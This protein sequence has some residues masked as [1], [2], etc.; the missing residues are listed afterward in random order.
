MLPLADRYLGS[1]TKHDYPGNFGNPDAASSALPALFGAA[2]RGSADGTVRIRRVMRAIPLERVEDWVGWACSRLSGTKCHLDDSRFRRPMSSTATLYA[3]SEGKN[4]VSYV[5]RH[6][7]C[8]LARHA[9]VLTNNSLTHAR[10]DSI[11]RYAAENATSVRSFTKGRLTFIN[12][13]R[14]SECLRRRSSRISVST[15]EIL[16]RVFRSTVASCHACPAVRWLRGDIPPE[17]TAPP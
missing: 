2:G 8:H 16:A 7:G 9:I 12:A 15:S 11:H 13:S 17:D 10:L 6:E 3:S 14:S 1:S 4:M 5:W